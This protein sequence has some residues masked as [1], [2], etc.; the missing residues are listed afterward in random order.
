MTDILAEKIV[1][2]GNHEVVFQVVRADE[3]ATLA[4]Q[5]LMMRW[6]NDVSLLDLGR[7]C[8]IKWE[9]VHEAC[10]AGVRVEDGGW[11]TCAFCQRFADHACTGCPIEVYTE[12]PQCWSTPYGDYCRELDNPNSTPEALKDAAREELLFVKAVVEWM[13]ESNYQL[14]DDNEIP[15]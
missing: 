2:V 15:F 11:P 1:K 7:L 13:I 12:E 14:E 6:I 9:I 10:S 4:A 3:K 8:I 5:G